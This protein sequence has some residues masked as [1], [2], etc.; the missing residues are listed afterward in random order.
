MTAV[1]NV[2]SL[3]VFSVVARHLNLTHAAREMNVSQ[4]SVSYHIKKIEDDLGAALFERCAEGVRLTERGAEG[5]S[6]SL[7]PALS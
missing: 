1:K 7:L 3:Q 5:V 2:K 6:G 4:S